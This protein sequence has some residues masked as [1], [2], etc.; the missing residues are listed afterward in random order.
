MSKST[1]HD[2]ESARCLKYHA[3]MLNMSSITANKDTAY[4]FDRYLAKHLL[5]RVHS[6]HFH[7]CVEESVK[8]Y[9]N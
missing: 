2:Q 5:E 1:G 8:K 3:L 7:E 4:F 9:N 6:I